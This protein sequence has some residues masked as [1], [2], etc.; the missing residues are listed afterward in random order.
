MAYFLP[1]FWLATV[2]DVLQADWHD[3]WHSPHPEFFRSVFNVVL[4]TVLI[5]FI[6]FPPKISKLIVWIHINIILIE[7]KH[8]LLHFGHFTRFICIF[9]TDIY[10]G[11]SADDTDQ[12]TWCD[13]SDGFDIKCNS[14]FEIAMQKQPA[15]LRPNFLC[16]SDEQEE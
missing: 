1:Q 2:Q 9:C 14:M 7:C 5:W 4:F 11:N 15:E 3:V 10:T 8:F 13:H 16:C 6:M 12:N